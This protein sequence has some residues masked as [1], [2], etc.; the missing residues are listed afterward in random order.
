MILRLLVATALLL[1]SSGMVH[2]QGT[3]D[4]ILTVDPYPTPY[5]S[6]WDSNPNIASLTLINSTAESQSVRIH[7]NVINHANRIVVSGTS[8][9]ELIAGGATVIFDNPYDV[10]G[11]TTHDREMEEIAAR[12]GRMPEGDYTACAV[13]TDGSGFVLAE[14]CAMFRIVYPDPPLLLGPMDEE[15][16]EQ[17][18]PLFT[19]T[20]VQVPIDY[21]L[22]Y[23]VRLVEV[24]SHQSAA[25]ALRENIPHFESVE[26]AFT[27]LRYPLEAQPLESG[28]TYAW[29]VQVLDHNGYAAAA[30]EGRS[31]IWTFRYTDEIAVN[32]ETPSSRVSLSIVNTRAT[33]GGAAPDGTGDAGICE[34]W[35]SADPIDGFVYP[36]A[37]NWA[38]P[39][40]ARVD[41][42]TLVRDTVRD[43]NGRRVWAMYGST[44]KHMLMHVGDCG[45]SNRS[46][47]TRWTAI[48][49]LGDAQEL[50]SW[51]ATDTTEFLSRGEA[52]AKLKF[53]VAILSYFEDTPG[54]EESLEAVNRYL[55]GHELE[56]RPGLNLFGVLDARLLKV[57][58]LLE[59]LGHD[60]NTAEIELQGYAGLS[61][62]VSA[63]GVIGNETTGANLGATQEF[64][65]V[66][67]AMPERR[68]DG[69]PVKSLRTGIELIFGDSMGIS[70]DANEAG[71]L[72]R[73]QDFS[74]HPVIKL[75]VTMVTQR[76]E[77]APEIT[78][79]GALEIDIGIDV[80]D[81]YAVDTKPTLR[82][83]TDHAWQPWEAVDLA[84]GNPEVAFA[85]NDGLFN[86][87][88]S[89]DVQQLDADLT[90]RGSLILHDEDIAK[91]AV[92]FGRHA[93]DPQ[94]YWQSQV[95]RS[96]E[97]LTRNIHMLSDLR[98]QED[99][100]RARG[101]TAGVNE[102][103]RRYAEVDQV[104][105]QA[106][107]QLRRDSVILAGYDKRYAEGNR[108]V[109]QE[110]EKGKWYWKASL[111]LGNMG[112]ADLLDLIRD[113]GLA[114][115]REGSE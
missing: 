114:A 104:V 102:A 107:T 69:G 71:R 11:S 91:V 113:I 77:A 27:S 109:T 38:W 12:T 25:A 93:N 56:I 22:S 31:E 87:I 6:D 7:F 52:D 61:T 94:K 57:W 17:T 95:G 112:L 45:M 53:G 8:S 110:V 1:G 54:D 43:S 48:R 55:E 2:A 36:L 44:S 20:P 101:D 74:L 26:N 81:S 84:L 51:L 75:T 86:A 16:L 79:D 72:E 62:T 41:S 108:A 24:Q 23:V 59:G 19:W 68:F 10:A 105:T 40:L 14:A 9:P 50:Q 29:S 88:G 30:N 18:D 70:A 63:E 115:R 73:G 82:L 83:T 39:G 76:D 46:T 78:W 100:A 49:T 67:A 65:V 89:R 28:K 42:A 35:E 58:P 60:A 64:L 85:I 98:R 99:A 97:D 21:Q 15:V 34:N 32:T 90:L 92:T 4:A 37:S 13:A 106:R 3:W 96:A 80:L 5:Y 66:R 33:D 103:R 111:T 47:R